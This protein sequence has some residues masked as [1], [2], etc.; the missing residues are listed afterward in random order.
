MQ[1]IYVIAGGD[2]L[3]Q[4]LN[5]IVTFMSTENWVVIR[6]IATAFSVLVVAIS[7]I[8]RHNIMDML[9]WAGVIVLMSLLVSV[10]T[11]VQI[12]D[13]SNQTKVYKVD[14]V[15]VGLALPASL[16]TKIGYAL[17]QGYEMVFSQPDSITYS[18]TGMI[19]G[20]NLVSRSTDFLSQ[21]P[22]IT[23][24]FT[25]YVQNCV[26]GDIFLNGKYTMEDLMNSA[27]P[28]TLIFSKPSPLRGIFNNN[29]QFLTCEE[30]AA[31]IKPKLALD[32]QTGGKTWSYYV[33]QLFGG[34][35]NPD[36][37]FSQMI[38]DSYNYFYGAGQSAASI[39]RQNVTMNALRNGIMS[40]AA[41]NGDTSSLLN[42]ATTSSMEKQRL[43]HAT[44]GQVALRSLPMSQTLIVGLTI[45]IFPLMVLGGM[46]NAVT[47]NVLKGYVLAIMWVQSWPLLYAILNSCM[48]FYAKA[49][50]SPV[51]LSELSQVQIKYSDLATTAGYLSMLIPPLAWGMLKGLGA[52]FSNLYSHLASSAISPAATAASGAVDGNYSYANMQTE[53]VSG[54]SWNT[55][56][57]T[58]FG[59]MSQQLGNGATSTQMRDG[60]TVTDSTQAAS[61]LPVSINFARQLASAQQEMA[62]EAQTQSQSAMQSFS[63][64]MSSTWQTLSQFGTNRGSSDSMTQGADS[65]MSAQDSMMASKMRTAVESY[66]KA[67]NISNDQATQELASRSSRASAGLY[68]DASAHGGIGIKA[69]GTG[70]GVSFRAGAKAGVDFDDLDSHQA[71]SSTRASQDARHDIDAKFTKDF[72]EASDYFTSRK[73]NE[74]GSHT[75]N[76]AASRA[77]QL[78]A[79][80]SSAKQSL[81]QY[82]TSQARSKEYAEMASRTETMSGQVNEDLNQQFAQYVRKQAP[83][84]ADSLLTDTGSPEVAAKR[85][86]LAWSFVQSQVQPSVDNAYSD[87]KDGLGQSMD[88]VSAGG[89]RQEVLSDHAAH[90]AS[91]ESATSDAGIKGNVKGSVDGMM[92][93]TRNNI[94]GTQ[95]EIKGASASVDN[96]YSALERHHQSE[97]DNQG[98]KY[99]NEKASQ[100][101][102]PGADSPEELLEK[103]KKLENNHKK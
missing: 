94:S 62:R 20:A 73:I 53:N 56:S 90:K 96:Q 91:I 97:A 26:M 68:G 83:H 60:S 69:F 35:P 50:G 17:V 81:E 47:L 14:N 41:R 37:L 88:N 38:G 16:T 98:A 43:A 23:T 78:S 15:P 48:T 99:N 65:T 49:N 95:S 5:A 8:R 27:D 75:D 2:W 13:I 25:D 79:S 30:A 28:Y 31:V 89:G 59:Q 45:G 54:N 33:R 40:Y 34:R 103:A 64:S 70:G 71:S 92:T 84:D 67:H 87:A 86:E 21:N 61:K 46:F 32:T 63:S 9:G 24:I 74:S 51:V 72:K 29:N 42:I 58:M 44:V 22:E 76:N 102:I 57:S 93:E 6:R 7:W 85:R 18:K 10:R 52:G 1:E 36:I 82:S 66:A 3:T 19:F 4:T 80:L 100:K 39:V 77:D 11:S 101:S 55:N 12:I